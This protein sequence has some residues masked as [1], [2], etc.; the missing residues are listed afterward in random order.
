LYGDLK[1]QQS[2]QGG[3][4]LVTLYNKEKVIGWSVEEE[5]DKYNHVVG[6]GQILLSFVGQ[7]KG[8]LLI[9][10]A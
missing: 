6:K 8:F 4:E 10:K 5:N 9:L 3:N 7:G 1:D 2:A